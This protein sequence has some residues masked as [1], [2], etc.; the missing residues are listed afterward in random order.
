[1]NNLRKYGHKPFNIAVIH[2][3]PGAPGEMAAVARGL[4]PDMGVLEPLQTANSIQG[5]VEELKN[6]LEKYGNPP[7]IVI[8]F[9]WGAWLSY[10]LTAR[11]PLLVKK[12]ILI[13]SGPFEEKYTAK[14]MET[15]LN[16]LNAD[17]REEAL[18]LLVVLNSGDLKGKGFARFGELM[19]K[20]DSCDPLPYDS[21]ILPCNP[22]IYQK[23]W[24]EAGKM[25]S[26]EELLQLGKKIPCPVVAIHG[27]Y[28]P[29]P[30]AG[31]QVPLTRVLKDF[32]FIILERCGHHPW[33]ERQAKGNF[34]NALR[35]EINPLGD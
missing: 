17:E 21:E 18:T 4:S 24:T 8:G 20:A 22:D 30:V 26:S 5:Q 12:L 11:Y 6:I 2:G 7:L 1:M 16:H 25:R 10:I 13:G 23:V 28:D 19:N 9:S 35:R 29:H 32:R 14:I 31:V 3:G 34:Y 15:R 33:L 27:D